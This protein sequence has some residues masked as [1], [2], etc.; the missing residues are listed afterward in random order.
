[1]L[2]RLFWYTKRRQAGLPNIYCKSNIYAFVSNLTILTFPKVTDWHLLGG[3]YWGQLTQVGH[4]AQRWREVEKWEGI[5]SFHTDRFFKCNALHSASLGTYSH[6]KPQPS[7]FPV[8]FFFLIVI[9]PMQGWTATTKHGVT[10]KRSTT[11]LRHI[12]NLFRTNLQLKD[13][14]NS[15]LKAT[16]TIGQRKAF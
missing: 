14:V 3:M 15:G 1:M 10:G 2:T 16:T 7:I 5:M 8:F 9:R 11:R 12:G 4:K 6:S 13:S